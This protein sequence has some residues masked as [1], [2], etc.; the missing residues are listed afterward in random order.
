MRCQRFSDSTL[1][2]DFIRWSGYGSDDV[3]LFATLP[4]SPVLNT[5]P[6]K[7]VSPICR[8]ETAQ[9][10]PCLPLPPPNLSHTMIPPVFDHILGVIITVIAGDRTEAFYWTA[11]A[12]PRNPT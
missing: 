10:P 2:F 6:E 11:G 5:P 7:L 3:R 12:A 9:V 8:S 4:I 1:C